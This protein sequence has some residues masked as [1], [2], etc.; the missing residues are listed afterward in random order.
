MKKELYLG[1]SEKRITPEVGGRLYGYNDSTFSESV[2]DDLTATAFFFTDGETKVLLISATVCLI[3]TELASEIRKQLA[4]SC[5]VPYENCMLCASHTHSGPCTT[6][7]AGWGG[8]DTAYCETIFIPRILEAAGEAMKNPVAVEMGIGCGKSDVGINRRQLREDNTIMLGQNPWGPYCPDMTVLSFRAKDGTVV[9]NMIHYGAHCTAA[10]RNTEITRDWAGVM[11]DRLRQLTG[12]VTAFFNGFEGDVG[13]RLTNGYTTGDIHY[14]E[15]LGGIAAQDAVRIYNQIRSWHTPSLSCSTGKV[16]IPLEKR[17][18]RE[19]A[20]AEI[21]YHSQFPKRTVSC[22]RVEQCKK[23]IASL[24][25]G[26]QDT[27]YEEKEQN[28]LK[29][30]DVAF[31]GFPFEVFSEVGM[32]ISRASAIPYVLCLSNVN[33]DGGYFI[34]EDSIARGGYEVQMFLYKF[35]Q[36]YAKNAD[37]H[38]MTETVKNLEVISCTE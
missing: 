17:L 37:W 18:D 30:G 5:G 33:G 20:E 35:E 32:R 14:A 10:G 16:R 1:V 13:P 2:H 24:E 36:P 21:A 23:I 22:L 25:K 9:A 27:A 6:G 19:E 26:V 31:V 29:I 11:V 12:A 7:S 28:I 3:G 38:L 34:T 8:I 4:E 15:E